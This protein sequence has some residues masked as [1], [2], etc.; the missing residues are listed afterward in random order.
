MPSS[1]SEAHASLEPSPGSQYH[2]FRPAAFCLLSAAV[3]GIAHLAVGQRR[4]GTLLL[5]FFAVPLLGFWPLRVLQYYAGFVGLFCSWIVLGIY[6]G[7]TAFLSSRTQKTERPSKWWLVVL[8]PACVVI[9]SLTGAALTRLTGFR[10]FEIPSTGM[11]PTIRKGD[12]IVADMHYYRSRA[13]NRGDTILFKR[14]N[15]FY[16]KRVIAAGGDSVEGR[17]QVIYVNGKKLYESYVE[18]IGDAPEW[19]NT[20]GPVSVPTGKFFVMGDNRDYSLDSR[21]EDYGFVDQPST[22]GK[23]LYV[24]ES[25]RAG[26]SIH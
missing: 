22:V 6:A 24:F 10:S 17:N 15:I 14:E 9:L 11:E 5:I 8:A 18:H 7:C 16:V 23:P 21:S 26:Q 1:L 19:A 25:D 2:P 3:P 13:P 4:K 20:F 12:R